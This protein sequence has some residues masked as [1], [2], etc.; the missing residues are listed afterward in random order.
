MRTQ[1]ILKGLIL[2]GGSGGG[3]RVDDKIYKH[4]LN[5]IYLRMNNICELFPNKVG[6]NNLYI[7]L[8]ESASIHCAY[9]PGLKLKLN[10]QSLKQLLTK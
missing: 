6:T 1:W 7:F 9:A 4:L 8:W 2:I 10:I 3:G 5:S